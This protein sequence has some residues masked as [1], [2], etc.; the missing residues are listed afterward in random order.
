MSKRSNVQENDMGNSRQQDLAQQRKEAIAEHTAARAAYR[1]TGKTERINAANK[2][3]AALAED[4]Y[5][6]SAGIDPNY[7]RDY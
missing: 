5:I 1:R 4:L 6:D 3:L 2:K 7:C